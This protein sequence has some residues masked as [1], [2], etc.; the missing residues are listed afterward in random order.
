MNGSTRSW[1]SGAQRLEVV[2][3]AHPPERVEVA[4]QLVG[5]ERRQGFDDGAGLREA[6]AASATASAT[7]GSTGIPQPASSI[8]PTRSPPTS[9]VDGPRSSHGR[10]EGGSA[11]QS[12]L[13][14]RLMTDISSAASCDRPGHRTGHPAQVGGVERYSPG[15]G[16]ERREAQ[17]RS[18]QPDRA[19]DVGPDVEGRVPRCRRRSGTG[20]GPAG[21][22]RRV[23]GAA[24]DAVQARDAGREHPPVRHDGGPDDHRP[25]LGEPLD[26]G[27]AAVGH[28]GDDTPALPAGMGTPARARFSL[29]V[30]GRRPAVRAGSPRR[31]RSVLS[32]RGRPGGLVGAVPQGVELRLGVVHDG[33][34]GLHHLGGGEAAVGVGGAELGSGQP[35][36]LPRVAHST[37]LAPEGPPT[38]LTGPIIR[39]T[40]SPRRSRSGRGEVPHAPRASRMRH[41]G[42]CCSSCHWPAGGSQGLRVRTEM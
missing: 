7:S 8:S 31:Q 15:A 37:A 10:S 19:A 40:P 12:R 25:R 4:E 17:P 36:D 24:A 14:G 20:R 22:Q 34:S 21:G 5:E 30:A 33:Q 42:P 9:G 1:P 18:G 35:G 2:P 16:L 29:T 28:D 3:R 39:R 23:P 13:S 27:G 26:D 38:G 11:V 6:W 41:A 32:R